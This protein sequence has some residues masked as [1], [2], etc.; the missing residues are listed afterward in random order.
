[1]KKSV[2]TVFL[3]IMLLMSACGTATEAAPP[4]PTPAPEITAAPEAEA[5]T[6]AKP[7]S[8]RPEN[9]QP[10]QD[11]VSGTEA[12]EKTAEYMASVEEQS[13]QIKA[14]LTGAMTQLEMNTSAGQLYTLWDDALNYLWAELKAVLPEERFSLLLDEQLAWIAEK[15]TAVEE[16]G[17]EVEGG[18]MYPLVVNSTAAEITETRVYELYELLR[19]YNSK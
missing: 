10:E 14:A 12:W 5:G 4:T 18:S 1:M 15:E 16:A 19:Q 8:A 9:T 13:E 7:E 2:L 11:G 17:K 6:A 3:A